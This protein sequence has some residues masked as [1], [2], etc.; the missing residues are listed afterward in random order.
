MNKLLIL[1]IVLVAISVA[2][3]FIFILAIKDYSISEVLIVV[4]DKINNS[5]KDKTGDDLKG[6][7]KNKKTED[8]VTIFDKKLDKDRTFCMLGSIKIDSGNVSEENFSSK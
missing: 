4:K 1:L 5:D 6:G 8:C 2:T 7:K 3:S